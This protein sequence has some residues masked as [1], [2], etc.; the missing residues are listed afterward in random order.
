MREI[1][2]KA[3]V[4]NLNSIVDA[5]QAQGVEVSEPVT[6]HDVVYG[7]SGVDGTADSNSAW[8]RVRSEMRNGEIVHTFT[9]KKSVTNQLDSIEHETVVE[10][11]DELN[12]I[13]KLLGYELFSD[14]TKT[15]QKA[16]INEIEICIDHVHD[17]GY[18]VEAE[19]LTANEVDYSEVVA[20]LWALLESLG[21]SR[22]N[23]ITDGY[24]VL[25]NKKLAK[26]ATINSVA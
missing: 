20:G 12:R 14:L 1:E 17:L 23:E 19:K 6:Q 15:R 21:V 18:F 16:H 3:S 7:P 5:L 25:M 9:L 26:N 8:L 11:A 4:E 13:I 22:E 2:V 24:D 10:N